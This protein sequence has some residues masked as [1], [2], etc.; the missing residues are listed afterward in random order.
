M[1]SEEFYSFLLS[2]LHL[3]QTSRHLLFRATV[4]ERHVAAKAFGC[5]ARVHGCV[6]SSHDEHMVSRVYGRVGVWVGCIHE[7]HACEIFV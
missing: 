2:M 1:Q 3:L 6:S 4:N 7:V 5:A